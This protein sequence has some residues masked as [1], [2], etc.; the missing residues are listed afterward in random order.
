ML[1][2]E[3]E[4]NVKKARQALDAALEAEREAR[5]SIKA[6]AEELAAEVSAAEEALSLISSEEAE[7]RKECDVASHEVARL[8]ESGIGTV[9]G[10][11]QAQ[12]LAAARKIRDGKL[13]EL[14]EILAKRE[15]AMARGDIAGKVLSMIKESSATLSEQGRL[16]ALRTP[17]G[18]GRALAAA[19]LA[20]VG[21]SGEGHEQDASVA[22]RKQ[23]A[24]S[25]VRR[26]RSNSAAKSGRRSSF[27]DSL[28]DFFGVDFASVGSGSMVL[29]VDVCSSSCR[30]CNALTYRSLT[31]ISVQVAERE[32]ERAPYGRDDDAEKRGRKSSDVS[33]ASMYVD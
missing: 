12:L 14:E 32:M 19:G 3:Q 29:V 23:S 22:A 17:P 11:V 9:A 25:I 26:I 5:K 10:S 4:V 8:K 1:S 24:P 2:T 18:K 27:D 28:A 30:H 6:F 16:R 20:G 33:V 31:S 21:R 7:R 13:L 15:D